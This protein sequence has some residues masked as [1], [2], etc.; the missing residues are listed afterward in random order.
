MLTSR[1]K[2]PIEF[3]SYEHIHK[4]NHSRETERELEKIIKILESG[5]LGYYPDLLK[6]AKDKLQQINPKHK[7]V[8]CE[9]EPVNKLDCLEPGLK[10][11]IKNELSEWCKEMKQKEDTTT[12]VEKKNNET[13]DGKNQPQTLQQHQSGNSTLIRDVNQTTNMNQKTNRIK[14]SDY[15]AWDRFDPDVEM[16]KMDVAIE[17]EKV[18][19]RRNELKEKKKEEKEKEYLT[20][21]EK[22]SQ[23]N[24]LRFK[25]NEAYTS[26]K[27]A[28]AIQLYTASISLHP[29]ALTLG[30]R[31]QVYI[32]QGN[33]NLALTDCEEALRIDPSYVKGMYRKALALYNLKRY[34]EASEW[35]NSVLQLEPGNQTVHDYLTKLHSKVPVKMKLDGNH[36]GQLGVNGRAGTSVKIIELEDKDDE[37]LEDGNQLTEGTAGQ[38]RT[39]E[40]K[41]S[42]FDDEGVNEEAYT[43]VKITELDDEDERTSTG[44]QNV[45]ITTIDNRNT[46]NGED[47]LKITF[48]DDKENMGENNEK[49]K[50]ETTKIRQLKQSQNEWGLIKQPCTCKGG[51][52]EFIKQFEE[53]KQKKINKN[54]VLAS[55]GGDWKSIRANR[56]TSETNKGATLNKN[57]SGTSKTHTNPCGTN[58]IPSTSGGG[59][60]PTGTSSGNHRNPLGNFPIASGTSRIH[61][62]NPCGTNTSAARNIEPKG[63]SNRNTKSSND[64]KRKYN[65]FLNVDE[66]YKPASIVDM[67]GTTQQGGVGRNNT[68]NLVSEEIEIVQKSKRDNKGS[69]TRSSCQQK[70]KI[71]ILNSVDFEEE[72]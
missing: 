13:Q 33:Y 2:I 45:K 64:I 66:E 1:Y 20:E 50:A 41:I 60:I 70:P 61:T 8:R 29:T 19:A 3:I 68:E 37:N 36:A 12:S 25:G 48:L 10:N 27:H 22:R 35:F 34:K 72:D 38:H 6:T 67:L 53:N 15:A 40:M 59:W 47:T 62:T 49:S 16:K 69:N 4:L 54:T 46:E 30:N 24:A 18:K 31:A 71:E 11:Q 9:P 28:L 44:K 58:E 23:A 39:N 21:E 43:P 14:S 57:P 52:P 7:Q 56:N 32:K 17:R 42:P 65:E 55:A 63:S 5:E 26:G 51:R